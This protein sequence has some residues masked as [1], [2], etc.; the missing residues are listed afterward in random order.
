MLIRLNG[1]EGNS[2]SR[3]AGV[4]TTGLT[5]I[6]LHKT[7]PEEVRKSAI[8]LGCAGMAGMEEAVR[9]GCMKAYQERGRSVCIIDGVV[10]GVGL[11]VNACK[12][13]F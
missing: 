11:L 9:E 12:A 1:N 4:E 7:P 10:A 6:Q 13:N 5:A 3:F 2:T 8:C